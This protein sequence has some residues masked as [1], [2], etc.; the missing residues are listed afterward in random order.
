MTPEPAIHPTDFL[1]WRPRPDAPM[2]LGRL[3]AHAHAQDWGSGVWYDLHLVAA[4]WP[5]STR[6]SRTWARW[7]QPALVYLRL[8][9]VHGVP[10]PERAG[11]DPRASHRRLWR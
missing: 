1:R 10:T 2:Q 9:L 7:T 5:A 8:V 6:S 3:R 4:I 11:G